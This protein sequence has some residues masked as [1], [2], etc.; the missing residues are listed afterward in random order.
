M[1]LVVRN[2]TLDLHLQFGVPIINSNALRFFSDNY[3]TIQFTQVHSV[4][5]IVCERESVCA[6]VKVS[7]I[8]Y[9]VMNKNSDSIKRRDKRKIFVFSRRQDC[10]MTNLL[11]CGLEA[12]FNILDYQ[13]LNY[14][15]FRCGCFCN[16]LL[17]YELL[18]CSKT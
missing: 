18:L 10:R 15:N 3:E 14:A 13:L 9:K 5:V 2:A 8:H 4:S 11:W 12:P 17:Y 16:M 1:H 7:S 6:C